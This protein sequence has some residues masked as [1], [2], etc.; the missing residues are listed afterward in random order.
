MFLLFSQYNCNVILVDWQNGARGPQYP[1]AAANT[2][3][4]GRVVGFLLL[5]LVNRGLKTKNIHLIGFS[6]GAHVAGTA[7][8]VLKK[9]H[10][11]I[12]R[13]TGLDAASP[14]FRSDH[15]REKYKKLDKEDAVF[16]DVLHTDASPVFRY[17]S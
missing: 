13:I 4:V 5:D 15:L 11:L 3:V 2:E 17:S 6:L 16:V 7:S 10:H 9:R 12:Q 1:I 14:L 8:E